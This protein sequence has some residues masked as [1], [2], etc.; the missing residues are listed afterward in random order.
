M[1]M[2]YTRCRKEGKTSGEYAAILRN[3]MTSCNKEM[4]DAIAKASKQA[5]R[6]EDDDMVVQVIGTVEKHVV[7]IVFANSVFVLSSIRAPV[8]TLPLVSVL[9]T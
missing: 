3:V 2:E 5:P 7:E 1:D 8:S 4:E 6:P 9:P